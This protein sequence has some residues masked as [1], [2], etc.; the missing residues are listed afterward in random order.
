MLELSTEWMESFEVSWVEL[1]MLA[2]IVRRLYQ[3]GCDIAP[4]EWKG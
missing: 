2:R 4:V 1:L 3:H